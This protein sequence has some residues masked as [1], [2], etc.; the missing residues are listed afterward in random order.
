MMAETYYAIRIGTQKKHIPYLKLQDGK[1]T[2]ELFA[3]KADA[4]ASCVL[5]PGWKV[6][7]VKLAYAGR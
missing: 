1:T 6:V 7:K 2:P 4:V 5:Q 3:A